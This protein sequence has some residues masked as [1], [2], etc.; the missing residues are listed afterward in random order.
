MQLELT[1]HDIANRLLED[2]Y[3]NWSR[4][5]AF[6]L[7]EWREDMEEATGEETM[8]DVVALRCEFSEYGSLID[9]ASEYFGGSGDWQEP[10]GV[11]GVNLSME[12]TEDAIRDYI[13]DNGLL[14]EFKGGVIVSSF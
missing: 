13:N 1:T 9:W 10:L 3:A 8:L 12:D 5:G 4:A 14:I 2:E 7:A 6:T 11:D